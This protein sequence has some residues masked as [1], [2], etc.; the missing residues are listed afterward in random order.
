MTLSHLLSTLPNQ[1]LLLNNLFQRDDGLWQANLRTS[2]QATEFG[3][4]ST[5]EEAIE[6]TLAKPRIAL[7][8]GPTCLPD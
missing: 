2:S 4:G 7:R 5:P 3:L 6:E 8:K 1:G